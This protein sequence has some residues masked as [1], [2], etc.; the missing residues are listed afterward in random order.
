MQA[1]VARYS[2]DLSNAAVRPGTNIGI[3][4]STYSVEGVEV[5]VHG[6]LEDGSRSLPE[7]EIV[8]LVW[9]FMTVGWEFITERYC[10]R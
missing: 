9:S 3:V 6:D 2:L 7:D 5:L 8:Q 4:H 10:S 1:G